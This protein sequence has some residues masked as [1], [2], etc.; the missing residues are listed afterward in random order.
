MRKKI[1]GLCCFA[2]GKGKGHKPQ[3][4]D[5]RSQETLNNNI[6]VNPV[7]TDRPHAMNAPASA[8]EAES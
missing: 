1:E 4:S 5:F 8:L 6:N 7:R 3:N 2:M